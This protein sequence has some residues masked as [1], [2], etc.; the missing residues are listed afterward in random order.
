MTVDV[1]RDLDDVE[2]VDFGE[3]VRFGHRGAGH[4]GQLRVQPEIV[5]ERDRSEGL[6]FRLDRDVFLGLQRL[7]QPFGEPASR[8]SCGR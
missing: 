5:L 7:V 1:G 6:V 3:L 4:A 8:A 2:L